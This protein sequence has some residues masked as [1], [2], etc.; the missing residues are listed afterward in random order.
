MREKRHKKET[1]QGAP[2]RNGALFVLGGLL[3]LGL[4]LAGARFVQLQVFEAERLSNY[5]E[6]QR[7]RRVETP[8]QR[9]TIFDRSGRVLAQ[10]VRVYTLAVDPR[11]IADS[12]DDYV[13]ARQ[14]AEE[15]T[16]QDLDTLREELAQ[17]FA[18]Q[19]EL[20]TEDL[21][22]QFS[23]H[24][25]SGNLSRYS[26]LMRNVS[27][28][29][30][31]KVNHDAERNSDDSPEERL[32]KQILRHSIWEADYMRTYPM[33]ETAAQIVGFVNA[34]GYGAAGIELQYEELLRG[35]PGASFTERDVAGN[36]IPA[37]VQKTIDVQ[38]GSDIMLTIDAEISYVAQ[39]ALE[40]AVRDTQAKAA[41]AIVMN[42]RT[43]EIYAAVSYPG[44]DANEFNTA[45]QAAIRNRGLVDVL[46][47]GSTIKPLTFA[48]AFDNNTIVPEDTF[49]V[50]NMMQVGTREI[51]DAEVRPSEVMNI[52]RI[53]EV[54]SNVGTTRIAQEL[55]GRNL[56]N[57]FEKFGIMDRPGL[58]FP[59]AV[60]GHVLSP[61]EWS[62]VTLSNF[63]FGQG[64]S[65][66]SLQLTRALAAIANDGVMTTPHLLQAVPDGSFEIEPREEQQV[67]SK[68]AARK[69]TDTL[70]ATMLVGTGRNIQVQNYEVAGKTGTAQKA[71]E[72]VAGY[73]EGLYISSF[74]GY[75]P[76]HDPELMIS[77]FVDEPSMGTF[78]AEVAGPP[79]AS[80]ATFA[81]GYLGLN[82]GQP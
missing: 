61:E 57:Y 73:V 1:N 44:F 17:Y 38:R 31:Q 54:S 8:A 11:K 72:G 50:P 16:L 24:A 67:V 2:S 30:R 27:P 21:L 65:M 10:S 53:M 47:P 26:I 56:Y 62:D 14:S 25:A 58:D 18:D 6:Q 19:L 69:T 32:F 41:S 36:I 79:F 42:P 13:E 71:I 64:L 40:E 5:A 29:I 9:G 23:R 60:R 68:E 78:G 35:E 81:V 46:E 74:M 66:T 76:A 43:G 4:C 59:G 3:T 37:G 15:P 51:S 20:P 22:P 55:G 39:N 34:E 75:L 52:S 80:I 82:P 49:Y 28:E 12:F 48:A 63:S 77:I 70:R 7:Q 33:G 45:D